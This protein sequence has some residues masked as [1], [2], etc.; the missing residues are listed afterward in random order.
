MEGGE[1]RSNSRL[2]EVL[3]LRKFYER[4]K[5]VCIP[6]VMVYKQYFCHCLK[7]NLDPINR[8][9]FGKV[10]RFVFPGVGARRLGSRGDNRY[11]Y[12]GIRRKPQNKKN[13]HTKLT[14]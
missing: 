13:K 4:A 10:V 14:H 5:G 12:S 8:A 9:N 11:Y 7:Y 3:W 1:H 2:L 6:R